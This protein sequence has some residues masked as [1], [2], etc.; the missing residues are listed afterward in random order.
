MLF[1]SF[2]SH[3]YSNVVALAWSSCTVHK[4]NF[5]LILLI[6]C[7]FLLW[8]QGTGISNCITSI[9][10]G[11]WSSCLVMEFEGTQLIWRPCFNLVT[12]QLNWSIHTKVI[13]LDSKITFTSWYE[14]LVLE[15]NDIIK[16]NWCSKILHHHIAF[17][18]HP[19]PPA[20]PQFIK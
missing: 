13:Q 5:C 15:L 17:N 3:W 6:E 7:L 11:T 10:I 12:F 4:N 18:T 16:K 14:T 20:L 2:I 1:S 19:F 8:S 9:N